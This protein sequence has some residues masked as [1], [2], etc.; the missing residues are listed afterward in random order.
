MMSLAFSEL[1]QLTLIM[2]KMKIEKNE[3]HVIYI[4]DT[5]SIDIR[6]LPSEIYEYKVSVMALCAGRLPF[7]KLTIRIG[8]ERRSCR[9]DR[10]TSKEEGRQREQEQHPLSHATPTPPPASP[11]SPPPPPGFGAGGSAEYLI[12]RTTSC[13]VS[14]RSGIPAVTGGAIRRMTLLAA[15]IHSIFL[16]LSFCSPSTHGTT[17]WHYHSNHSCHGCS[18]ARDELAKIRLEIIKREILEKLGLDAPPQVRPQDGFPTIP[19]VAKYLKYQLRH[20]SATSPVHTSFLADELM[21]PERKAERTIILA[22]RTPARF[23]LNPNQVLAHFKFSDELMSK[24]LLSAVL[25][26]YLRKPTKLH[27]DSR[28]AAVQVL[29]K[30]VVKNNSGVGMTCLLQKFVTHLP[31]F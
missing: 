11:V 3:L 23:N 1:K 26:I 27:P 21:I 31:S 18:E 9:T 28:I 25:N 12:I 14:T 16:A 6:L 5:A 10:T 8:L 24:L 15:S 29:V 30:E 13:R 4:D 7:P 22:E 2:V 19:Q 20:D 17:A